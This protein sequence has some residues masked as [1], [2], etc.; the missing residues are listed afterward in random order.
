MFGNV[1]GQPRRVK[2]K[3]LTLPKKKLPGNI[4]PFGGL[5]SDLRGSYYNKTHPLLL[6]SELAEPVHR[7]RTPTCAAQRKAFLDA[8]FDQLL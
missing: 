1:W 6:S 2:E 7:V 5:G 8:H 3:A 4:K